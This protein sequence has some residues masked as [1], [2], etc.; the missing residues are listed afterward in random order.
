MENEEQKITIEQFKKV[1]MIVGEI[2]EAEKVPN[3]DT[4]IRLS[5]DMGEENPRQIVSGIVAYFP[6]PL[7]LVG[8]KCVFAGNLEPRVIRGLKSDGM[9]LAAETKDGQ[10]ALMVPD[11]DVPVG[12]R[13]G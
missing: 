13:I 4:L 11:G 2:L 9:I 8:K 6:D 3:A 10:L 12:T 5:V 7:L 1:G